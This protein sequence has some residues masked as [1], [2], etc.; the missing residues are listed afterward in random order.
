[1]DAHLVHAAQ[2]GWG[3]DLTLTHA[4]GG[5]VATLGRDADSLV[6]RP[7]HEAL[8][9]PP[10]RARALDQAAREASDEG[11]VE[12]VSAA[13]WEDE[14][15][16][17]HLRLV[18]RA[19]GGGRASA[20]VMNLTRLLNGAPPV[21]IARLSSHLSHEIRNP[22]SSVKMA[23]QTLARN[24]T[25]GERDRRRLSIANRE[26]R[27]MERM[28]WLLSE[29][30]RDTAPNLEPT[31]LRTLVQEAGALVGPEL[32]ERRV[33]LRVEG[34]GEAEGSPGGGLPRVRVDAARLR[35]VLA[36]LLLNVAMGQP[37]DSAL[38]VELAPLPGG[39]VALRLKDLGAELPPEEQPVLFE[40]FRSRVARGAGLSLAALRRVML[41]QG[42]EVLAEDGLEAGS[43]APGLVFTLIFST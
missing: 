43:Q 23:V 24:T 2:L 3:E 15:H 1:M 25:L 11:T 7:L 34:P 41:G 38:E 21:Q 4:S 18:L 14:E 22:L 42:G 20:G 6:G 10:E 19:E 9:I 40:P 28:L 17:T 16:P 13:A 27:T 12:F 5:L 35:P 33:E 26:I 29:Y 39:R 31:S 8:R 30:G 36:Q 37:E 32:A